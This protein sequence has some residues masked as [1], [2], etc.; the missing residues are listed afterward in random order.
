MPGRMPGVGARRLLEWG[1]ATTEPRSQVRDGVGVLV[2]SGSPVRRV[3]PN[4]RVRDGRV[5][6]LL[7]EG[8]VEVLWADGTPERVLSS[9][10]AVTGRFERP[11]GL[12][13]LR[14][15]WRVDPFA[16]RTRRY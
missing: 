10:L 6:E 11:D 5:V 14:P 7:G 12:I 8:V 1:E 3:R 15:D 4:G 13:D 9:G 16:P 2:F